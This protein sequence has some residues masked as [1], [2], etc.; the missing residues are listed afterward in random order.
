MNIFK[1]LF[2]NF[3]I[4]LL[5]RYGIIKFEII[6]EVKKRKKNLSFQK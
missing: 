6:G 3:I 1:Y 5:T 2:T 4:N